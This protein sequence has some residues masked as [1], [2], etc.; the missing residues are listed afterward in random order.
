MRHS[1][2]SRYSKAE[3]S[4]K[5]NGD[6]SA[7]ANVGGVIGRFFARAR[8][9]IVGLILLSLLLAACGGGT[10]SDTSSDTPQS[11]VAISASESTEKTSS[12]DPPSS[13]VSETPAAQSVSPSATASS[14]TPATSAPSETAGDLT[15]LYQEEID[16]LIAATERVRGLK[17]LTPPKVVLLSPEDFSEKAVSGLDENLEDIDSEDAMYKLLGLLE[18][19]TSLREIY[20][21]MFSGATT[22]YYDS[23]KKELVIPVRE[24]GIDTDTRLTLVHELVHA[25]T[26][27]H[28][29]FHKTSEELADNDQTDQYF[30]L[31]AVIEGDAVE[32]ETRYYSEE[33]TDEEKAEL[34]ASNSTEQSAS[35]APGSIPPSQE[36]IQGEIDRHLPS[37]ATG[38]SDSPDAPR[39]PKFLSISFQFSYTH[40]SGFLR[41]LVGREP[42]N[43][44]EVLDDEDFRA[45]NELYAKIPASTEQIYFSEKYQS[46]EPLEVDHRV[47]DL[48]GYELVETNTWGSLTFAAMF[49]QVLGFDVP[50]QSA[51]ADLIGE[52]GLPTAEFIL[53]A[54]PRRK[55][56]DGWGG[57]RYS[58]WYNGS[59]VAMAMTYRGDEASDAE[60]L[61]E[62]MREYISTGMNVGEPEI[63]G[64]AETSGGPAASDDTAASGYSVTW[65]G[66]DFAW[67]KV[68]GD[69]LRFVAASDPAVGAELAAFYEAV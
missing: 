39:I 67:L 9:L 5:L 45:I 30:A 32:A 33:M 68:E 24:S 66:E 46:E 16:E 37:E 4:L 48:P 40:G 19:G 59:E 7:V 2:Y 34:A 63:S 12:S 61:A 41:S 11:S 3:R 58:L 54:S 29:D 43:L 15:A 27:Q 60:E 8:C 14:P 1:R 56:V 47:A 57:D 53:Q 21:T 50:D 35:G 44:D 26:D 52:D 65:S 31:S 38:S 22:G 28:F 17:F 13:Q 36:I 20:H 51:M 55:A 25:L 62:T 64:E 23:E 42:M 10:G 6:L 49:D 18:P 69:T